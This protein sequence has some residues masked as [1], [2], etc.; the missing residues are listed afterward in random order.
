VE[1]LDVWCTSADVRALVVQ[2]DMEVMARCTNV[3]SSCSKSY[4]KQSRHETC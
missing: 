1:S 3:V 2:A 4:A